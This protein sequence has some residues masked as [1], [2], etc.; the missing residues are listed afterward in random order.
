M[1]RQRKYLKLTRL[2][3]HLANSA[4]W[5][6]PAFSPFARNQT[7]RLNSS[8]A[9]FWV[10]AVRPQRRPAFCQT[11]SWPAQKNPSKH[12]RSNIKS[13]TRIQT[14]LVRCFERAQARAG[15]CVCLTTYQLSVSR[16]GSRP[17]GFNKVAV[18]TSS[19]CMAERID[20]SPSLLRAARGGNSHS[21]RGKSRFLGL[22]KAACTAETACRSLM[23][24]VTFCY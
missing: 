13:E 19:T 22:P 7:M 12:T 23:K 6:P 17:N 4:C 2:A 15:V 5:R 20:P 8:R 11:P 24:Q 21:M 16:Q 14:P 18:L 10:P 3:I 9:M 1:P